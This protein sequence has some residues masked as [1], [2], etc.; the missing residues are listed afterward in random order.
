[1]A[2][3]LPAHL[4]SAFRELNVEW[5]REDEDH[6]RACATAIRG[7]ATALSSEVNPAAHGAV[8]H[9]A[10][11][12]AGDHMDELNRRWAEYHDDGEQRGHLQALAVS[13]NVLADGLDLLARVIEIVKAILRL[14]AAYVFMVLAWAVAT[15]LVS[16]GIGVLA[17]LRAR[18]SVSILRVFARRAVANLRVKFERYFGRKLIRAVET[19]LR[20]M[21]GAKPPNFPAKPRLRRSLAD[22]GALT[23]AAGGAFLLAE[24]PERHPHGPPD[25][26]KGGP[27]SG[28]YKLGPPQDPGIRYDNP[29]PYDPDAKPTAK[30]YALWYKWRGLMRGGESTPFIGDAAAA[31]KHYLDGSGTD[32]DVDFERAY[33]EDKGVRD[34]VEAAIRQAQDNAE[35]LHRESGRN[36]FQMT[37]APKAALPMETKNWHNLLGHSAVWGS[38]DVKIHGNQATMELTVN[39]YDRYNFNRM[40]HG[41]KTGPINQENGRLE[42]LGW[43]RSFDTRGS[44]TRTVTWPIK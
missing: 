27:W 39:V 20:R 42:E 14:L 35:R 16:G 6:V 10:T 33:R 18:G 3:T 2:I 17:A 40:E 24:R 11:N 21:L 32:F 9:A 19:R 28:E 30:D 25:L 44:L 36:E 4:E 8:A 34:S 15:S 38:G 26:P 12:N 37:G 43:A 41:V 22:V 7:C 29:W 13:L 31:Y 1:M 23:A 5:P